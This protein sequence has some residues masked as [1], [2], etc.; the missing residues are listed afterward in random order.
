MQLLAI[1]QPFILN[2]VTTVAA[3]WF[4]VRERATASGMG[5]LAMYLGIFLGLACMFIAVLA[6][7]GH[8]ALFFNIP[9]FVIVCGGS[10]GGYPTRHAAKSTL[11]L[12]SRASPLQLPWSPNG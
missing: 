7:G 5:S 11:F 6:D 8:F 10:A 1:G 2:A 9:A 3:R 4:P 12:L